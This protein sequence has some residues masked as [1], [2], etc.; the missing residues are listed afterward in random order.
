MLHCLAQALRVRGFSLEITSDPEAGL[1]MLQE[2]QDIDLAL[3]DV[4]MPRL[5]GFEVYRELLK[6]RRLPVLF[7][8]AFPRSFDA[9]QGDVKEM[10]KKQ[11]VDGLTDIIYKPFD[12]KVLYEKVESLIGAAR[13][14]AEAVT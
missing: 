8:T 1:K 6:T 13:A 11:F 2:R 9:K 12:L 10:W 14:E 7:V 4:R 5:N 3:L